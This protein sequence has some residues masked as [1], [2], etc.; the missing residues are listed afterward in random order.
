MP[1]TWQPKLQ[2]THHNLDATAAAN[3][4]T[5]RRGSHV[6]ANRA[7]PLSFNASKPLPYGSTSSDALPTIAGINMQSARTT[8]RKL[9]I[10]LRM[11]GILTTLACAYFA[12]W[13]PTAICGVDDVSQLLAAENNDIPVRPAA[14]APLVL[15]H[16]LYRIRTAA[17]SKQ[18]VRS[19]R[20]FLWYFGYVVELPCASET[21]VGNLT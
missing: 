12:C 3:N 1:S 2:R 15:V 17:A 6:G 4:L 7:K 9:R 14:K 18:I 20:Y 21:M 16:D 19:R 10:S 5:R 13:R 11:L 8:P